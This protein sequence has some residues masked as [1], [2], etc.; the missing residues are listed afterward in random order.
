MCGAQTSPEATQ[1]TAY[2]DNLKRF[3]RGAP[4]CDC[5]I[6][7]AWGQQVEGRS[8]A[9][10]F[11]NE[12]MGHGM[13]ATV[14][15]APSGYI[16][17]YGGELLTRDEA[18]Q[19]AVRTHLKAVG[20]GGYV[21][22]GIDVANLPS[23]HWGALANSRTHANAKFTNVRSDSWPRE[24]HGVL[25]DIIVLQAGSKGIKAGEWITLDYAVMRS[26]ASSS[27]DVSSSPMAPNTNAHGSGDGAG[28]GSSGGGSYAVDALSGADGQTPP[29]RRAPSQHDTHKYTRQ[30]LY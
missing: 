1:P 11:V 15:I 6:T 18:E 22:D 8:L 25:P 7:G 24:L 10:V 30:S 19:R 4:A 5:G 17:V 28:G 13:R 2:L 14:D 26:S 27:T 29:V 23:T 3:L 12:E 16:T 21:I 20:H 9:R